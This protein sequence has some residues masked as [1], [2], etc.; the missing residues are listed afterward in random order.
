MIKNSELKS[1][2]INQL[3]K[4]EEP[5]FCPVGLHQKKRLEYYCRTCQQSVCTVC[6]TLSHPDHELEYIYQ[7][8]RKRKERRVVVYI[9]LCSYVSSNLAA[10][11][12][13]GAIGCV[14]DFKSISI[15]C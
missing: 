5:S 14:A 1:L 9:Y 4:E 3:R 11:R 2:D 13:S 15:N 10:P 8:A 6:I 12:A 7:E